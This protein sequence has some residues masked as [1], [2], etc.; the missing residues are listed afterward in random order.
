[1]SERVARREKKMENEKRRRRKNSIEERSWEK[2]EKLLPKKGNVKGQNEQGRK[3][4]QRIGIL[5]IFGTDIL[6]LVMF[7]CICL[8]CKES[9]NS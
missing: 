4:E 1:M 9:E 2:I 6:A 8:Y 3:E 5:E 7:M